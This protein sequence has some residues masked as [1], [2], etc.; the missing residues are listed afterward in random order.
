[1][2]PYVQPAGAA[3]EV[4]GSNILT[5]RHILIYCGEKRT[6]MNL[7]PGIWNF[8]KALRCS[9]TRQVNLPT[10]IQFLQATVRIAITADTANMVTRNLV[11]STAGKASGFVKF[12]RTAV[13]GGNIATPKEYCGA[14][15]VMD[16][17]LMASRIGY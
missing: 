2:H 16:N 17:R 5:P 11:C 12:R 1:M 3:F 7:E 10:N 9:F 6:S 14:H 4:E 15:K 13:G 8:L